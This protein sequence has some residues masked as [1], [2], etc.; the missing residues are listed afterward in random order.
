MQERSRD[1]KDE[2]PKRVFAVA[3]DY[4]KENYESYNA[5]NTNVDLNEV[6]LSNESFGPSKS[7]KRDLYHTE[8]DKQNYESSHQKRPFFRGRPTPAD[9]TD[10]DTGSVMPGDLWTGSRISSNTRQPARDD[11]QFYSHMSE[12]ESRCL[13][14]E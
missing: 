12:A 5:K 4:D 9:E 3:D 8:Y 11:S 7:Y 2:K 10:Y 13:E 14:W 6:R 1:D